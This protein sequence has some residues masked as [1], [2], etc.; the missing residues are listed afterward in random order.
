VKDGENGYTY[1]CG[2]VPSLAS[3]LGTL[4]RVGPDGRRA[5][6]KRSREIVAGF[7]I[8]VAANATVAAVEAVTART[9]RGPAR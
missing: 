8:D 1:A 4:V 9:T 3:K 2:D 5:M 6:G 7:G